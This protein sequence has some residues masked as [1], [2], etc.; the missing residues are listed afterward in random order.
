MNILVMSSWYPSKSN[1]VSGIFVYEQVKA[2]KALGEN[3]IVFYPFDKSIEKGKVV[4]NIEEDI[5]VYRSNTDYIKNTKISRINSIIKSVNILSKIIKNEKID[6]IHAHVCYIAG[7][8]AAVHNMFYKKTPYI[9]TE[10]SSK[11]KEYSNKTYNKKLFYFA[12]KNAE[13]V[14]T[15]SNSLKEELK[16]LG[17]TFNNEI[18]GNIVNTNEY[19]IK[20]KSQFT[21][22]LKGLFIGLMN[23]NEVKGLQYF[24]PALENLLKNYSNSIKFTFIGDGPKRIKYE[25]MVKELNINNICNFIGGVPKKD[26]P[27]YIM[28]HDFLVLPSVKETFGSVLIEAMAA[29]KPVLAT[30]CGGPDEFVTKDVGLLV[31]KESEEALE[32]G[33]IYIIDNYRKFNSYNIRK[34]AIENYSYE[35]IG[36]R[37]IDLY[38]SILN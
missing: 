17:Y 35:A 24:L 36:N 7:I 19:C 20:E 12:Y 23:D 26:I 21:T 3:V 22:E 4:K 5:V 6:L 33:L 37:L 28:D 14:I 1:L 31:E 2:L 29:G 32:K 38:N 15:V 9:I 16:N 25:A 27:K 30:K 34:Y 10:H 13:K 11:V 18:I 8:I